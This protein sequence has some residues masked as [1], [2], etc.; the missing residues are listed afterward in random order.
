[1]RG[2]GLEGRDER[3]D[4]V[5]HVRKRVRPHHDDVDLGGERAKAFSPLRGSRKVE[6]TWQ[7]KTRGNEG[8][9]LHRVLA[10]TGEV[11]LEVEE[12]GT[13]RNEYQRID[14]P[15]GGT[16]GIRGCQLGKEAS[17]QASFS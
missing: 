5:A 15:E 2:H 16:A 9:S 12:G 4:E 1:M 3:N 7:G 8:L 13:S 17:S 10:D 11:C 6:T 14:R